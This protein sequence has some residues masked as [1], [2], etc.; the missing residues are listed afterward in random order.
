MRGTATWALVVGLMVGFAGG[1]AI[2]HE[3]VA[4]WSRSRHRHVATAPEAPRA[5]RCKAGAAHGTNAMG[6]EEPRELQC[7]PS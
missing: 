5:S 6:Y 1:A 7:L 2:L 4:H 3:H